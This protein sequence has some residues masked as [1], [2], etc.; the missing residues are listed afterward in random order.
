MSKFMDNFLTALVTTIVF[1]SMLSLLIYMTGRTHE[2]ERIYEMCIAEN[3]QMVY[4]DVVA[5]CK[6]VVRQRK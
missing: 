5:K 4:S 1:Y 2:N 3:T 6:H